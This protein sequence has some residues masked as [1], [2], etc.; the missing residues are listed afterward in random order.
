MEQ[1]T[2]VVDLDGTILHGHRRL[3]HRLPQPHLRHAQHRPAR[4]PGLVRGRG[5]PQCQPR[6][7]AVLGQFER[8][9]HRRRL[10]GP[11]IGQFGGR[12]QGAAVGEGQLPLAGQP[13]QPPEVLVVAEHD[14]LVPEALDAHRCRDLPVLVHHRL[15]RAVGEDHAVRDEGAVVDRLAEVAAVRPAMSGRGDTVVIEPDAP[16]SDRSAVVHTLQD[17]VVPELPDEPALKSRR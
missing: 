11:Q 6:L 14:A 15:G 17:A 3:R 4:G 12:G 9:R 13:G 8:Q 7:A 2:V 1:E 10:T 5:H 16:T